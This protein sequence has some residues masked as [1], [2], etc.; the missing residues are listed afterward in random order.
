MA[1]EAAQKRK[2]LH[3][4]AEDLRQNVSSVQ[5]G[6]TLKAWLAAYTTLS[7]DPIAGEDR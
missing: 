2:D 4:K 1:I 6:E 3:A 5:D 7:S